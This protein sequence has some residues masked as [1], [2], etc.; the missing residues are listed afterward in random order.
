MVSASLQKIWTQTGTAN[1]VVEKYI[2]VAKLD[3][4]APIL[5]LIVDAPSDYVGTERKI[6][7]VGHF[8]CIVE[9]KIIKIFGY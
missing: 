7:L 8:N 3:A 9:T 1:T 2:C 4:E 6:D 5:N